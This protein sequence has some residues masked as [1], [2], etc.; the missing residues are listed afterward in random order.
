MAVNPDKLNAFVGK[1]ANDLGAAMHG[2]A[3]LIGDQLGLYKALAASGPVT[4]EGLA[5][6]T[7][8]NERYLREWL[9]GQAASGYIEYDA[10]TKH[11]SMTPE[12]AFALTDENGPVFLP[13]AFYIVSAT[14]KDRNKVAE[15]IRTGK[16]FGWHEHHVDLFQGTKRF[17]RP[18]YVGNL[19]PSWLP[20]MEGVVAK[21]Q[22]GA[23]VADVG[24]GLGASTIIMAKAFPKSQF[25]GYDYH[26]ES[27]EWAR[28]DAVSEGVAKNTDFEVA[29]AKGFGGKDFDL[30]TFF[31]C[32]HDM[33]DPV[34]AAKHVHQALKPDGTWMVVEPFAGQSVEANLNP[35]GRIFYNASLQLCVPSSLSQEVGAAL[36]AQATDAS[37]TEVFRA[38]GFTRISKAVETPFNRVFAARP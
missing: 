3:I 37:L 15:A 16:G 20:S 9:A 36:G 25:I 21:L 24:C 30:V 22:A 6:K 38:G 33:G 4:S 31:D 34:G 14:Y 26:G 28:N 17:F 35:V 12:Q 13:G 10:P 2:S 1:F 19:V 7:G 29:S 23:R 32:L 8:T 27:I 18:G 5:H 11:Y